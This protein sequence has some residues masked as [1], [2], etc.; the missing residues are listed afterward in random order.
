MRLIGLVFLL[1]LSACG[2]GRD[3]PEA[4]K[5][6]ALK[7]L[8][9]ESKQPGGLILTESYFAQNSGG[10]PVLCGVV[11]AADGPRAFHVMFASDGEV[12][13]LSDSTEPPAGSEVLCSP[14]AR[15]RYN[16]TNQ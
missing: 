16:A 2:A 8:E 15:A 10:I 13:A 14:E 1:A 3:S 12:A 5:E 9:A 7:A 4:R 6:R 11:R